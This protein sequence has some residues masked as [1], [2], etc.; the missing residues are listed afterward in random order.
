MRGEI[1]VET[2][3]ACWV[4]ALRLGSWTGHS[5]SAATHKSVTTIQRLVREWELAGDVVRDGFGPRRQIK[6]RIADHARTRLV[7]AQ[8][9]EGNLWT[10]MR[11]LKLAFSPTDL[12]AHASTPELM[13][14]QEMAQAYCGLLVSSGHLRMTSLPTAGHRQ[15]PVYRLILDTGP[16]APRKRMLPAVVDDNTGARTMLGG[17]AAA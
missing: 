6:Y 12:A 13:I 14:S 7:R 15:A 17:E 9:I 8:S 1:S 16:L 10:A 5:L 4:A 2:R 3:E 11:Q